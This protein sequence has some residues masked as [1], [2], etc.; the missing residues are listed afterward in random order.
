[1]LPSSFFVVTG[2]LSHTTSGKRIRP[3]STQ[4]KQGPEAFQPRPENPAQGS[5]STPFLARIS[6]F[7]VRLQA[8]IERQR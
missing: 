1:M 8:R 3:I 7:V 5:G 6:D 2:Q 4:A